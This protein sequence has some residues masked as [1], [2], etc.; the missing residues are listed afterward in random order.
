MRPILDCHSLC[1]GTGHCS[2]LPCKAAA[3]GVLG[4]D[5]SQL[6]YPMIL[7]SSP[8][9]CRR[10][11]LT[12]LLHLFISHCC[13]Q[14][15]PEWPC[16]NHTGKVTNAAWNP[17]KGKYF[18]VQ[19]GSSLGFIGILFGLNFQISQSLNW[20]L[21]KWPQIWTTGLILQPSRSKDNDFIII[22]RAA[23]ILSPETQ[24]KH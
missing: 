8:A 16:W 12:L 14:A 10:I 19:H 15:H 24:K 17:G 21:H 20:T 5:V 23:I 9:W 6:C 7:S 1:T 3:P 2:L 22:R 18:E 13:P 4:A 11:Q